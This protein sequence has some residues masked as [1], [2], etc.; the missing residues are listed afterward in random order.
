MLTHT[1]STATVPSLAWPVRVPGL[2]AIVAQALTTGSRKLRSAPRQPG[3][4]PV[5]FTWL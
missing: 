2:F 3:L 1:I 4:K 5:P